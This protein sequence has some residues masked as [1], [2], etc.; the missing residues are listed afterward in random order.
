MRCGHLL[1]ACN[2]SFDHESCDSTYIS[3]NMPCDR[4]SKHPYNSLS[5]I[6]HILLGTSDRGGS[7]L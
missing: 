5:L 6:A 7:L 1:W 4:C 3:L 2:C